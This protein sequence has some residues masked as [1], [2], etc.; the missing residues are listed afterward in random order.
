MASLIATRQKRGSTELQLMQLR[1]REL[2]ALVVDVRR[3]TPA[4]DL[5]IEFLRQLPAGFVCRTEHPLAHARNVSFEDLLAYPIAS[6]PLANE[7]ARIII[8]RYGSKAD[9]KSMTTLECEDVTSLIDT[10]HRTDA[11]FLGII[12]AAKAGIKAGK[13]VELKIKPALNAS[14]Q[15][16]YITL[17]GSTM[18]PIMSFFRKFVSEHLSD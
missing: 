10:I 9:P 3:V 13:L 4:P 17:T 8:E 7:V 15:F 5:H 18:A 2:D 6:T 1:A 14:A 12:A 16:A 11:I